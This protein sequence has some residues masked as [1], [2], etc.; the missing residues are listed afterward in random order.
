MGYGSVCGVIFDVFGCLECDRRMYKG[1]GGLV[2]YILGCSGAENG[3]KWAT[4]G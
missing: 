1:Y 4:M 2:Y 3:L